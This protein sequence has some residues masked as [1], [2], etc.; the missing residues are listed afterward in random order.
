MV[1]ENHSIMYHPPQQGKTHVHTVSCKMILLLT[2]NITQT[3]YLF[4]E[5]MRSLILIIYIS[6]DCLFVC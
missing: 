5:F 1:F 4:S 3:I 6:G 2:R